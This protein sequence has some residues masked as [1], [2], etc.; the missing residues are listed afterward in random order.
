MHI[1][2]LQKKAFVIRRDIIKMISEAGSGH[3]GGSLSAVDILVA[4]YYSEIKVDSKNPK[5][6]ERDRFVLSKGHG[7]PALYA[8][9][10]DKGFFD[11]ELLFTIR[12]LGSILQGH[13]DMVKVPG[14]EM[15]TGSLGQ[16]FSASV[17][18][19]LSLKVDQKPNRVYV[20]LGDGENQEGIVWEAAMA[21]GNY[22]LDNLTVIL[23][24][25]GFQIDGLCSKIMCVEPLKDKWTSFGFHVL[26]IDGHDM[27]AILEAFKTAKTIKEKPT[28]IIA[29]TIKGK[30]VSFME[31]Q[32]SWHGKAPN[33]EQATLALEELV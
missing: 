17:G 26:V 11:K 22:K 24:N 1:D 20:L 27:T 32:V 30:G 31:N 6:E 7:V 23:D 28:I 33:K 16:G 18:M 12:K 10:A 4:L 2:L 15:S 14:I 19:A 9:L 3:P 25:N 13:P 8:I 21:A 5:W 29:K